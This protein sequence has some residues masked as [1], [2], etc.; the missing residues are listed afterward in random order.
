MSDHPVDVLLRL[1]R[2]AELEV[3]LEVVAEMRAAC[4]E[5]VD[6]TNPHEAFCAWVE[7]EYER[8]IGIKP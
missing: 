6:T 4:D 3:D 5:P 2:L 8:A 1:R 7:R